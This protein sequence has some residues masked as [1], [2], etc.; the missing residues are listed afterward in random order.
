WRFS[1]SKNFGKRNPSPA[2]VLHLG[3]R[4]R[5]TFKSKRSAYVAEGAVSER[6][7][8]GT[9]RDAARGGSYYGSFQLAVLNNGAKLQGKWIG[10]REDVRTIEVGAWTWDRA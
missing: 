3:N 5:A 10:H 1:G 7:I 9:W 8:T 4:F 2:E 6:L